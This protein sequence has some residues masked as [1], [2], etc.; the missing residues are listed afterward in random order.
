MPP[1][2]PKPTSST[3]PKPKPKPKPKRS[4][5]YI[6]REILEALIFS[7][8]F[9]WRNNSGAFWSHGRQAY[10][11]VQGIGRINGVSDILGVLPDGKI[12]AVEVKSKTGKLTQ[13]QEDFLRK[14]SN[15]GGL[16][17]M[18]RSLEDLQKAFRLHTTPWPIPKLPMSAEQ[19]LEAEGWVKTG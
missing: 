1:P 3:K 4:E 9:V 6:Q 19:R 7:G 5:T 18:V 15:R 13:E 16:A 11:K 14:V 12:L 8:Y 10:I 17:V 2:N